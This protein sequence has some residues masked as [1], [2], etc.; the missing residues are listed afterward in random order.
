MS[1]S[2]VSALFF[3]TLLIHG[4]D[5]KTDLFLNPSADFNPSVTRKHLTGCNIVSVKVSRQLLSIQTKQ[6][7]TPTSIYIDL[8]GLYE[9]QQTR[10]EL[11]QFSGFYSVIRVISFAAAW[12]TL[13]VS[14]VSV[15]R[16]L[17]G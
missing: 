3:G 16:R 7:P 12:D 4:E 15:Q 10:V 2:R 1:G 14:K 13:Q 6:P 11:C 5:V 9:E 8:G 17:G